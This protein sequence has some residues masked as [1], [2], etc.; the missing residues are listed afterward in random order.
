MSNNAHDQRGHISAVPGG[1][2]E[3][4]KTLAAS[5]RVSG[6]T[7]MQMTLSRGVDSLV[8]T[9]PSSATWNSPSSYYRGVSLIRFEAQYEAFVVFLVAIW[10]DARSGQE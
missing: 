3:P 5:G 4:K 10:P 2:G 9:P 1:A 7:G 6:S 8:H